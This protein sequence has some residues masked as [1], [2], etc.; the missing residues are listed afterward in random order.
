MSDSKIYLYE[1]LFLLDPAA[2]TDFVA[3]VEHVR[4]L[5]TRAGAELLVL[6]KW[7]ERRLAYE[8][9]K[10][11]RGIFLLAYFK[12]PGHAIAHIERDVSLSE[13]VIRVLMLRA[14]HI[15]EVELE[16]A[17]KDADLSLEAKLRAPAAEA[18]P[19]TA[20]ETAP[21]VAPA[22]DADSDESDD[23]EVEAKSDAVNN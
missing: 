23:S 7:D 19:E 2:C 10:Q 12:A 21:E 22:E 9:R 11:K 16:L 1:G 13:R 8:I 6:R 17:A 18:A 5:F 3:A 15:G 14:D 20:P 4:T